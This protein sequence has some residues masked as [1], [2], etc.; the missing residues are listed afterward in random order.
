MCIIFGAI[1][2][3]TFEILRFSFPS[4]KTFLEF[5][6]LSP[7]SWAMSNTDSSLFDK[8]SEFY[9]DYHFEA[10]DRNLSLD[11]AALES[12]N[13]FDLR[14]FKRDFENL[15]PNYLDAFI[16]AEKIY[17]FD[18]ELLAAIAYQESKWNQ[19]AVSFTG[20]RGLMML[21]QDTAD[22]V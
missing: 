15:L 5:E 22:F 1:I 9:L 19:D 11:I 2:V 7:I 17:N 18:W 3:V 16:Q 8:V 4:V 21:T 13:F 20:V 14:A 12:F 10:S 6:N